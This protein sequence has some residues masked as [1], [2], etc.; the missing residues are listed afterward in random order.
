MTCELHTEPVVGC[1]TATG[2][3]TTPVAIHYTYGN[4]AGGERI[5]ES[6]RYTNAAGDIVTLAAG[7]V[8]TPGACA[9]VAAGA[10]IDIVSTVEPGCSLGSG[11]TRRTDVT[12]DNATGLPTGQTVTYINA[13]GVPQAA[14]P[15]GFTLG[16][17]HPE[18]I[19]REYTTAV[20]VCVENPVGTFATAYARQL[21]EWRVTGI[22]VQTDT[23]TPQYSTDGVAWTPTAPAGTIRAGA[24]P[25]VPAT[26]TTTVT[27]LLAGQTQTI[28]AAPNLVSWSVRNRTSTTGT[29]RVNGGTILAFDVTEV[30][31]SGEIDEDRGQLTDSV[32]L[33]AGDGILRVTVVRRV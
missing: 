22:G 29:F 30:V 31:E 10:E 19:E 6:V 9:S 14:A 23:I 27:D 8:V 17:C 12:V 4:D 7:D 2:G 32:A 21:T 33:V 5:I 24:C 13:A 3:G 28:A 11:W 15:T 26:F 18:R 1:L 16:A 20:P 25:V